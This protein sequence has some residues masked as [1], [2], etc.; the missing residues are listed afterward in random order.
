MRIEATP[1]LVQERREPRASLASHRPPLKLYV[2][3][4]RIQLSRR[5]TPPRCNR[6]DQLNQLEST[7]FQPVSQP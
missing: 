7:E 6:R 4:S 1:W 2:Q 3:F 5:L